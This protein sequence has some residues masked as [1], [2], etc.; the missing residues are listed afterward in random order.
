MK[1]SNL[2]IFSL[3]NMDGQLIAETQFEENF[4]PEL[5]E[6]L[7]KKHQNPPPTG[8]QKYTIEPK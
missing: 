1:V 7:E 6:L 5:D 8:T 4:D 2:V 3:W